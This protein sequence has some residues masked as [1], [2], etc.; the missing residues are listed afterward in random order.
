MTIG[1]YWNALRLGVYQ[2]VIKTSIMW[3]CGKDLVLQNP[4][5]FTAG[6]F[7]HQGPN[8]KQMAETSFEFTFFAKGWERKK[9]ATT[10][11]TEVPNYE[12][13]TKVSGPEPGYIAT[14]I[15]VVAAALTIILDKIS[16]PYNGGVLT[17]SEAFY[18]SRFRPRLIARGIRFE[19]ISK[20]TIEAPAPAA[21]KNSKL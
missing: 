16:L 7:S 17:P 5:A 4:E 2:A 10:D 18:G 14:P 3:D 11:P 9:P 21:S 13:V 15:F 1:N 19:V 6:V 12:V 20:E 8:E